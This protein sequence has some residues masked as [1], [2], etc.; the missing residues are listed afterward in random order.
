MSTKD[1]SACE[2][3]N[4]V[5]DYAFDELAPAERRSM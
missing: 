3:A 1:N 5:P 2:R 4:L